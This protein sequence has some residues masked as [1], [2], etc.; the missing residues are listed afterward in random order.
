MHISINPLPLTNPLPRDLF[1][2]LDKLKAKGGPSEQG[3]LLGWSICTRTLRIGL[4]KDKYQ[5]WTLDVWT[6]IAQGAVTFDDLESIIGRLANAV[7]I[8]PQARYF[9]NRIRG[10]LQRRS[11]FQKSAKITETTTSDLHLCDR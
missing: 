1:F 8:I 11:N 4:L 9:L 10:L 2:A 5:A 6:C 3:I 7:M